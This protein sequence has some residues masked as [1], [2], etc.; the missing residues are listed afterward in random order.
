MVHVC[1]LFSLRTN[2]TNFWATKVGKEEGG[3]LRLH[4]TQFLTGSVCTVA[5]AMEFVHTKM[6]SKKLTPASC[7]ACLINPTSV[8]PLPGFG[9][10][11]DTL[12]ERQGCHYITSG[13]PP[14][15]CGLNVG[16]KAG[17]PM[18]HCTT[19]DT[20]TSHLWGLRPQVRIKDW[21]LLTVYRLSISPAVVLL[22]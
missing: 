17:P 16:I 2:V 18:C 12:G 1:P 4:T 3:T 19:V 9:P 11:E 6:C 7:A 13:L 21:A 20:R 8:V 14:L 10:G 22:V 15:G 5:S